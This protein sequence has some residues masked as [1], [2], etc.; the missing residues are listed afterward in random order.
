M[1]TLSERVQQA[2]RRHVKSCPSC[3]VDE[4]T[5]RVL[6]AC[7]AARVLLTR[8]EF[9]RW[10]RGLGDAS[11]TLDPDWER[12][13]PLLGY[14]HSFLWLEEHNVPGPVVHVRAAS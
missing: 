6:W 1:A 12:H 13:G 7:D 11:K 10:Q 3:S 14:R 4:D 9:F 8:L 2:L 5:R